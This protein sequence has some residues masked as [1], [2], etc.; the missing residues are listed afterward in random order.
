MVDLLRLG[1]TDAQAFG[2]VFI[3]EASLFIAATLMAAKIMDRRM[4]RASLVPGE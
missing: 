3:F 4:P 1:F 2:A